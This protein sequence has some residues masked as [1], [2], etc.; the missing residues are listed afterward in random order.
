MEKCQKTA[1]RWVGFF[2]YSHCS[3]YCVKLHFKDKRYKLGQAF[4]SLH[5]NA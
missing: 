1:G 5:L 4:C 2:F 3:C